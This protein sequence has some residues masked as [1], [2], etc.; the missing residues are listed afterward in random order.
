[1]YGD[2]SART[3]RRW[4]AEGRIR[5]WRLGPRLVKVDLDDIDAMMRP[6]GGVA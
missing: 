2:I 6:V 5:G 1:M 4:I 3:V